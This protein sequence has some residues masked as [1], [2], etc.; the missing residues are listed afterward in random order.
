MFQQK[1]IYIQV[2]LIFLLIANL[3]A[4]ELVEVNRNVTASSQE[5]LNKMSLEEKMGQMIIGGFVGTKANGDAKR[6]IKEAKIGS[7]VL[8]ANETNII[9]PVQTGKLTNELQKIA[10]ETDA[11]IPLFIA[12]D[13]EGGSV[14]RLKKGVTDLPGNMAL[15][16]TRNVKQAFEAGRILAKELR[17]VGIQMNLAPDVDVNNNA[18]NPVIGVRSFGENPQ[19]VAEMSAQMVKGMQ[20]Q[21]IMATAKHFP[22]HGDTVM[23]SHFGLPIVNKTIQALE[24]MELIPFRKVVEGKVDAIMTAH[25]DLPLLNGA[26]RKPATLSKPVL[27]DLLR[28]QMKFDGLI[29]TDS[30][31]MKGVAKSQDEIPQK[32]VESIQAG[33]DIVLMTPEVAI[34][35]QL[36]VHKA[37]VKAVEE[38]KIDKKQVDQSVFR[39][40]EAKKKYQ[41]FENNQ[42]DINKI[43]EKVKTDD[44]QT[45]AQQMANQ[46][47]TLVKNNQILPLKTQMRQKIGVISSKS[48]LKYVQK[49]SPSAKEMVIKQKP[50]KK[51]IQQAVV[52]AK[53]KKLVVLTTE[54]ANLH[55]E[56]LQLIQQLQ[57]INI[58][59]VV[60]GLGMPYELQKFPKVSGYIAAYG[61]KDTTLQAAVEVI[62]GKQVPKGKL[63]VSIPSMYKYGHGLTYKKQV[64]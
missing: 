20:S 28:K 32:A 41:L 31:V 8:F 21:Q 52:F 47:I 43:A 30:L 53:Q 44:N 33:A 50:S 1:K 15:G 26:T 7:M 6:L 23:D 56:Q 10:D 16:A 14:T 27:T 51:Q 17:A 11:R 29:I 24:K 5:I 46:S 62:F 57:R 13:Q 54:N 40:I 60:I 64:K 42:V 4:C 38:E 9:D 45:I 48:M 34:A 36:D 35:Q 63:P 2:F 19:L 59:I 18:K 12:T 39:I 49:Y 58:P 25:I 37:L 61:Q 22:G 3:V 55:K